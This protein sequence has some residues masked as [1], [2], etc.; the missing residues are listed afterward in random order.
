MNSLLKKYCFLIFFSLPTLVWAFEP[1]LIEKVTVKGNQR[2]EEKTIRSYLSVDKG[3]EVSEEASALMTKKLFSTG[4]F[5]NIELLKEGNELIIQIE[6]QPLINRVNITGVSD[7][8]K[9]AMKKFFKNAQIS[10]ARVLNEASLVQLKEGLRQHYL[11]EGYYQTEI[12]STVRDLPR[13]RVS[14]SVDIQK[15]EQAALR[16]IKLIGAQKISEQILLKQIEQTSTEEKWFFRGDRYSKQALLGDIEIIRAYYL[17]RGYLDFEVSNTNVSIS[18]DKRDV[19]VTLFLKEGQRYQVSSVRLL[20]NLILPVESILSSVSVRPNSMYSR[21]LVDETIDKIKRFYSDQGYRF[22]NVNAVP[23]VDEK[24]K[25]VGFVFYIAPGKKIGVRRIL[26]SGNVATKDEVIRREIRQIEGGWYQERKIELS[27]QRIQGLGYFD[28]VEV[29][30]VPIAGIE[31]QVDLLFR[32]TER[33]TGQVTAGIGYSTDTNVSFQFSIAKKNVAGS[34]NDASISLETSKNQKSASLSFT[35]PYFTEHGVSRTLN[36]Y[37]QSSSTD[38]LGIG[39]YNRKRIGTGVDFSIPISEFNSFGVGVSFDS[40]RVSLIPDYVP[41][42]WSRL[43]QLGPKSTPLDP[44]PGGKKTVQRSLKTVLLSAAWSWADIDNRFYPT[45]GAYAS[46]NLQVSPPGLDTRFYKT[47]VSLGGFIPLPSKGQALKLSASYSYADGYS[48]YELPF[49]ERYYAGGIGSVRGY[50]YY[51]LGPRDD[52]KTSV[53]IGG[54]TQWL[55]TLEYLFPFP[56]QVKSRSIRLGFF[57]DAGQV[58]DK[59]QK[60]N[61]KDLRLS[62]GLSLSWNTVLG[63]L[64]FS[65]GVPLND[66]LGDSIERFQ[67]TIGTGF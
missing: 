58:W 49:Y 44:V 18:S 55:S 3:D 57:L 20:G 43:V 54:N 19:Y 17:D 15:G 2:I 22:S 26:I 50:R 34:G 48:G 60:I 52:A 37:Y 36:A 8:E 51:S 1:F 35:D 63:Q 31:D 53:Q 61:L 13:N 66:R 9:K 42:A 10:E 30:P 32:V 46:I 28:H 64:K 38:G 67:F 47:K 27:R 29:T 40:S 6:E 14:L 16:Q 5:K 23:K 62:S 39:S 12:N 4:F 56:G 25:R 45:N 24:N 65:Y 11:N 7:S 21:R 33:A 41:E 59:K